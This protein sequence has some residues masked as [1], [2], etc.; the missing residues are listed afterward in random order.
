VSVLSAPSP[1]APRDCG[2]R[3]ENNIIRDDTPFE[4]QI[5]VNPRNR[6]NIVATY[7]LDALLSNVVRVSLDGRARRSHGSFNLPPPK[8]VTV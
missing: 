2:E 1:F 5:A 3:V 8:F 6:N 4:P 7:I